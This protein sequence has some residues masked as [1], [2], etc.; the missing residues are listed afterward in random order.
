M[1]SLEVFTERGSLQRIVITSVM[2]IILLAAI[3]T[4]RSVTVAQ[5]S[6]YL[7][8]LADDAAQSGLA[9]AKE[10]LT[11][12]DYVPRWT[13]SKPLRPNTDCSGNEKLACPSSSTDVRCFVLNAGLHR[14]TFSVTFTA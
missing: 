9:V 7:S 11:H 6:E 1:P 13:T 3:G 12:S 10:C 2:L 8:N 4:V 5:Q 14:S